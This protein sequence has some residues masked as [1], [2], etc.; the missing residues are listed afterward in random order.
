MGRGPVVAQKVAATAAARSKTYALHS[1]LIALAAQ[2]GGNPDEN[3]RLAMALAKAR[4]DS[5]T[6]DVIERAIKRGT[7]E[8][9][10]AARVEEVIYEGYA[11]GG[12]AVVARAL[13]DNRN[14]TAGN[15]RHHFDKNGGNLG[16]SGSVTGFTFAPK[17]IVFGKVGPDA[18]KFEEAAILSGCDEYFM[19]DD[20]IFSLVTAR[21]NLSSVAENV[22][23]AGLEVTSAAMHYVPVTKAEV[24]DFDTACKT[25]KL[26][27]DLD[28]DEEIEQVW[29]N[30]QISDE[31]RARAK[32]AAEKAKFRT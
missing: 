31:L 7:G 22:K 6:A 10:S 32:E 26:L 15:V 4:K 17:G 18:A 9:K 3:P 12:V 11:P 19:E 8:D 2:S 13:T 23:A 29:S 16:T 14:R 24:A 27:E 28:A 5:V 1:K 30:E 21:E 25:L 20:G